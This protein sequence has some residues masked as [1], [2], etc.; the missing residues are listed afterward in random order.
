MNTIIFLGLVT[1]VIILEAL[2]DVYTYLSWTK[3]TN[4][5][6]GVLA[7]SVQIVM[8]LVL[9]LVGYWLKSII[10]LSLYNGFVLLLTAGSLHLF[11]FDAFYNTFLGNSTVGSTSLWDRLITK[12]GLQK[13]GIVW[14]LIKGLLLFGSVVLLS[15]IM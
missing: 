3:P 8:M 4:K 13:L 7:H 5:V 9:V 1:I 15:N 2:T 10:E 11:L 14:V 6:Y 12:L